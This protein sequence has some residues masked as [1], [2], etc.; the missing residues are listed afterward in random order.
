MATKKNPLINI[1][2]LFA[3]FALRLTIYAQIQEIPHHILH[4]PV[5]L[6]QVIEKSEITSQDIQQKSR[7]GEIP[8]DMLLELSRDFTQLDTKEIWEEFSGN[9]AKQLYQPQWTT[10]TRTLDLLQIFDS[11]LPPFDRNGSYVGRVVANIGD[12]NGDDYNDWALG[13]RDAADFN[14][15][16]KLGKVYIFFGHALPTNEQDPDI[17]FEGEA[18]GDL[19]GG[20]VSSAGDVNNDGYDDV[21]VGALGND[22][23]GIGA[24]RAY[25]YFGGTSID[26]TADVIFTGEAAGDLF[27]YSVSSAGDVNNDGYDDVIVGANSNDAGG[28]WAGRAYIFFGGNSMDHTADVIFTGEAAGD[29]FGG[30]VS[31]AGDVNNDGYDDVILG[32]CQNNAGGIYAG[33]AYIFLGGPSMDNTAGV[34]FTGE[35]AMNYLGGSVSSAGD[36]N[37]DGYDDVI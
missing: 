33:R 37:N 8:M 31:S 19:F 25:I 14:T 17:I 18:G 12:I 5:L 1:I 23:G 35:A 7:N 32:A 21:I 6:E 3:I 29:H 20:S 13:L 36:V 9:F 30:S 16:E 22:T 24:G 15:S 27:G 26:N 2:L 4:D 28:T 10:D 34:I 11:G